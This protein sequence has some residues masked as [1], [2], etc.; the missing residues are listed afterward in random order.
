MKTICIV[1]IIVASGF[2]IGLFGGTHA[3]PKASATPHETAEPKASSSLLGE[4]D[5]P[6]F[7]KRRA[8]VDFAAATATEDLFERQRAMEESVSEASA[9]ECRVLLT[10][11][12]L[13]DVTAL[14]FISARWAAIDPNGMLTF[15]L[16]PDGLDFRDHSVVY[17]ELFKVWSRD[18]PDAASNAVASIK[19]RL[20]DP[21]QRQIIGHLLYSDPKKAMEI[22]ASAASVGHGLEEEFSDWSDDEPNIAAQLILGLPR[23]NFKSS[24]AMRL[25]E[26]WGETNPVA[27]MEFAEQ[28]EPVTRERA[29]EYLTKGWVRND[30]EQ[31]REHIERMTG[32]SLARLGKE[33]VGKVAQTDP[34]AAMDWLDNHLT[35]K[36][37]TEAI[38][39]VMN[40]GAT[41]HPAEIAQLAIDLPPGEVK[42]AALLNSIRAWHQRDPDAALNWADGLPDGHEKEAAARMLLDAAALDKNK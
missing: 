6:P 22:A 36:G 41:K 37:R 27:A 42:N 33:Y 35:G 38:K 11:C 9:G 4:R 19:P 15:L 3:R 10:E 14:R 26:R 25:A 30:P 23:C 12:S 21:Y 34:T 31:A 29:V 20:R 17:G 28:L 32:G 39:A 7:R 16:S 18:D 40:T 5:P 24:A 1:T 8:N 2:V 13:D